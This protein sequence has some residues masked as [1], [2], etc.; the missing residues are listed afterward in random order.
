MLSRRSIRCRSNHH[1]QSQYT[2]SGPSNPNSH[3]IMLGT[4]QDSLWSGLFRG[5]TLHEI[6]ILLI[7]TFFCLPVIPGPSDCQ[8]DWTWGRYHGG[9]RPSSDNSFHSPAIISPSSL[10]KPSIMKCYH[11]R[12]MCSHTSPRRS[13]M[14]VTLH[15]TRFVKCRCWNDSWTVKTVVT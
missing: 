8:L 7:I 3:P 12:R 6:G 4:W 9:R 11:H 15:D 2:D 10:D 1:I 13:P 14:M 5:T